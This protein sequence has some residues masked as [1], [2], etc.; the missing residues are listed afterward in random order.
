M[1]GQLQVALHACPGTVA[2]FE[3]R[4]IFVVGAGEFAQVGIF[5]AE[6]IA[7]GRAD[8]VFLVFAVAAQ[9][10]QKGLLAALVPARPIHS[11]T[12]FEEQVFVA[13]LLAVCV[14]RHRNC[15]S[16]TL[17]EAKGLYLWRRDAS[18]SMTFPLLFLREIFGGRR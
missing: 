18:L 13:E 1:I 2:R 4:I 14:S 5:A 8:G 6:Q 16:V 9:F 7:Q 3:H 17:S 15:L 10:V 12:D 11:R